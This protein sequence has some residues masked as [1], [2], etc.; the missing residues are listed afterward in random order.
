M[1]RVEERLRFEDDGVVTV[2]SG[3]VDYGQGLRAA[4]PRIVAE[5]LGI[6]HTRVRVVLGDTD[7]VPWDMGTFGSMSVEMD[8]LELRRAAAVARGILL[9]RA[10]AKLDCA[11]A[12]LV[13]SDGTIRNSAGGVA[14][15][16][17]ELVA[18]APISGLVPEDVQL[19]SPAPTCP[20]SPLDPTAR[21]IVT[22]KAEFVGDVHIPGMLHGAV[23]HSSV[24]GARLRS[25]HRAAVRRM[26]GV[27][28]LVEE[29]G[30]V[31]IVAEHPSQAIAA[32]RALDPLW[33]P[34]V[35]PSVESTEVILREDTD[36]DAALS[37]GVSHLAARYFTPH[38]A[39][40]PIG[41]SVGLVDIRGSD[42]DVYASTQVPFRLREQV[43]GVLGLTPEHVHVKPRSMS[44]G[45]GR[46]GSSDAAIEAARLAKAVGRP[47]RVQWGRADELH[48]APNRPE[49]TADIAGALDA[50]G[51][52]VAWRSAIT[53]NPYS[54][55]GAGRERGAQGATPA[56][57]GA[58][59]S[60]AQVVAMMAGRNA[61]PPYDLECAQIRLHV[62]PAT[63]RTGALRSLGASPNVFAIESFMDELAHAA[64]QDPIAFRLAHTRDARLRR[65]LETVRERSGWAQATRPF[66][67][68]V[69]CTVYRHTYVA[70]VAAVSVA[71]T[72]TIRLERV[73]CAVDAG[74]IV[75]PDGARNQIE[76]AIQMAASWALVEELPH[77]EG[78]VT[79]STWDQYPIATC[80]DAPQDIDVVF[81]GDDV[82]PSAGLGEPPVV[83]VAPAIA[84]A[85]FDACGARVRVLPILS[86]A[87]L[88]ALASHER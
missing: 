18:G 38:I 22:G 39:A 36:M 80:L 59:G 86:S 67:L 15:S 32:V 28:A 7:V 51:R 84:N 44:G 20:D 61:V 49:M 5:E 64:G 85:V 16:F 37:R 77:L 23:V 69:A 47:V 29:E 52:I 81:T 56:P 71:G 3:K 14:L 54:Y 53:T 57:A 6:A 72:G 33:E 13:V 31:G 48:A 40:A 1:S 87:V 62:V 55:D 34:P 21:D 65:V 2:F 46:F 74:H 60:P 35:P 41:P 42:A 79:G 43:A 82:T 26:P 30:F 45:Y 68:G 9:S 8:G 66:G 73:W 63:V 83:P 78:E 76:G 17:A 12:A 27:V 75:H 88:L 19:M 4:Y 11:A 50:S 58:W 24:H 25:V 70:Q 10:A